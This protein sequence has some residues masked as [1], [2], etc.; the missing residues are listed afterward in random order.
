LTSCGSRR[1]IAKAN[2]IDFPPAKL[3]LVFLIPDNYLG[4][5]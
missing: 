4:E 1:K 3:V 5:L 2:R